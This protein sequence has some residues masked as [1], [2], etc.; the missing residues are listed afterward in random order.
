MP[1]ITITEIIFKIF[2]NQKKFE[3]YTQKRKIYKEK[4]IEE[5]FIKKYINSEKIFKKIKKEK[6]LKVK[7]FKEK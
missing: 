1:K 6:I 7:H 3:R 2:L 4:H 5:K